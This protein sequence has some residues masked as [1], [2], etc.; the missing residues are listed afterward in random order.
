MSVNPASIS[1]GAVINAT[2]TYAAPVGI[3]NPRII[4][5]RAVTIK[6]SVVLLSD[7]VNKISVIR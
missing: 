2:T 3:P 1:A 7:K 5:R 4:L 6:R